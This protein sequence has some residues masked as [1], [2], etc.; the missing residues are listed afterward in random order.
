MWQA[1]VFVLGVSPAREIE[2]GKQCKW[3][4]CS[5]Q[6]NGNADGIRC[7]VHVLYIWMC[8]WDGGSV[9]VF[10]LCPP[11]T[12]SVHCSVV[13]QRQQEAAVTSPTLPSLPFHSL[14][15][16]CT[17]ALHRTVNIIMVKPANDHVFRDLPTHA[18]FLLYRA[19]FMWYDRQNPSSREPKHLEQRLV[20]WSYKRRSMP[21]AFA[22]LTFTCQQLTSV[23]STVE[24]ST[25]T[26]LSSGAGV[27]HTASRAL[28]D[29][30]A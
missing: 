13:Q 8:A 16:H 21:I 28:P 3:N 18:D 10:P 1:V 20:S 25:A 14:T 24:V 29:P 22:N 15:H 9:R 23:F 17:A 30:C 12:V 26:P 7:V 6:N 4:E 2:H 19:A 27:A 5:T 11:V